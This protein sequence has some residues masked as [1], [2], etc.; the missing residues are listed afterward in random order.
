[1]YYVLVLI[2]LS[3]NNNNKKMKGACLELIDIQSA[4]TN[5]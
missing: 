3:I 4:F 5:L 2:L 1:M